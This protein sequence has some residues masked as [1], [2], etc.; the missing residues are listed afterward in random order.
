MNTFFDE[1]GLLNIDEAVA[2]TPSFKKIMEDGIVTDEELLA[3]T[4]VVTELFHKVED[5]CTTEQ[6]DIVKNL[7]S[8]MNV[9]YAIYNYKELQSLK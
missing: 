6:L 4:E 8:E 9:L 1:N 2:N 7:L 3:Q 5:N